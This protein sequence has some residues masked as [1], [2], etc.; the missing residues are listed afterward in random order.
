[1]NLK[2]F[3]EGSRKFTVMAAVLLVGLVFRLINLVNG[4]ELVSLYSSVGV[5]FMGS[6]AIEK[7]TDVAKDFIA[8]KVSGK[9]EE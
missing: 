4:A 1:M 9:G 3:F 6:N 5:A 2:E 7:I 8:S